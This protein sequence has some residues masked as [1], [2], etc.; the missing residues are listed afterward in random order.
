MGDS[1]D[2]RSWYKRLFG[3]PPSREE[4]LEAEVAMLYHTV[5]TCQAYEMLVKAHLDR[6]GTLDPVDG[7]SIRKDD[8]NPIERYY[9]LVE[10]Q[11]QDTYRESKE[12]RRGSHPNLSFAVR[13]LYNQMVSKMSEKIVSD[14]L[15]KIFSGS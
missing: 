10:L 13:L 6:G 5:E 15:V 14:K 1:L 3:S 4:E 8:S 2:K 12:V 11:S 9:E 7:F